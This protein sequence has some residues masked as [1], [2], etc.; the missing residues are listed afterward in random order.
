MKGEFVSN[1]A[2]AAVYMQSMY[3]TDTNSGLVKNLNNNLLSD[4]PSYIHGYNVGDGY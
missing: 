3:E 1:F 2:K 4:M